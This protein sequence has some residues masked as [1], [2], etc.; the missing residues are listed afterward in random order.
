MN[1][2]IQEQLADPKSL[3]SLTKNSR[4][5]FEYDYAVY[6]GPRRFYDL[7]NRSLTS[8]ADSQISYSLTEIPNFLKVIDQPR[9]MILKKFGQPCQCPL[10]R[11]VGHRIDAT[12]YLHIGRGEGTL[13]I[14]NPDLGQGSI[15]LKKN[16]SIQIFQY[17]TQDTR[18]AIRTEGLMIIA[19]EILDPLPD[20]ILQ[21][22]EPIETFQFRPPLAVINQKSSFLS[23]P[24]TL[25]E[26]RNRIIFLDIECGSGD[27]GQPVLFSIAAINYE[28]EM[29]MLEYV[30]PRVHVQQYQTTFHGITESD[31]IGQ[32][33]EMEV[34]ADIERMCRGRVIVG[35]DLHL[36]HSVLC[37][38]LDRIAGVRDLQHSAAIAEC[39]PGDS[40]SLDRIVKHFGLGQQSKEHSA[41]EDVLLIREVYRK[42]EHRWKDTPMDQLERLRMKAVER[43][44]PPEPRLVKIHQTRSEAQIK[45]RHQAIKEQ[46]EREEQLRLEEQVKATKERQERLLKNTFVPPSFPSQYLSDKKIPLAIECAIPIPASLRSTV[47]IVNQKQPVK[48]SAEVQSTISKNSKFSIPAQCSVKSSV[49]VIGQP[50]TSVAITPTTT[51]P[52]TTPVPRNDN[53]L[54]SRDVTKKQPGLCGATDVAKSID[55]SSDPGMAGSNSSKPS[56]HPISPKIETARPK[57]TMDMLRAAARTKNPIAVDI[58]E[59][60]DIEDIAL[61]FSSSPIVQY[62]MVIPRRRRSATVDQEGDDS[63]EGLQF[64]VRKRSSHWTIL[65]SK[66]K[67]TRRS[68]VAK[69]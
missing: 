24:M 67:K 28:G 12:F 57:I 40:W 25:Q 1:F 15:P 36:E 51:T 16:T 6:E 52:V 11:I 22:V 23:S 21:R 34:R 60:D 59:G 31:L 61:Q 3:L 50:L 64:A 53:Q 17:Q 65:A 55:G 20:N 47:T 13:A 7:I 62:Q 8:G 69:K 18:F 10:E 56:E 29:L 32:R 26:I 42:V 37:I 35:H 19:L 4:N 49:S 43:R 48:P 9:R 39:V 27:D 58:D 41:L 44:P 66:P 14:S 54:E 63:D 30:C 46:T 33:D 2:E 68:D 5:H 45:K 38:N